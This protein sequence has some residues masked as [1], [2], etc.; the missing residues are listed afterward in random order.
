MKSVS[1]TKS[2][3]SRRRLSERPV[4]SSFQQKG[5]KTKRKKDFQTQKIKFRELQCGL[6]VDEVLKSLLVSHSL[7]F[8]KF[9][10]C[11]ALLFQREIFIH[12]IMHKATAGAHNF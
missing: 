5:F 11:F 9:C 7:N 10:F 12:N 8:L 1:E 6:E 4:S 2:L 3:I